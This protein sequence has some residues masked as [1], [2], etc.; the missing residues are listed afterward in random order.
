MSAKLHPEYTRPLGDHLTLR[1]IAIARLDQSDPERSYADLREALVQWDK[2]IVTARLG[3]NTV[4]WGVAESRHLVNIVNQTDYL[5]DLD[6]DEKLGQ[7]MAMVTYDGGSLGLIDLFAMTW[8]RRQKYPSREGRPGVP[9]AVLDELSVYESN[10]NEWNV[11]LAVRWSHSLRE[12]E[13]ALTYFHG[14]GREPELMPSGSTSQPTLL[15]QYPLISQAGLELQWTRGA[16]C[17]QD[18]GR[19]SLPRRVVLSTQPPVCSAARWISGPSSSTA[20]MEGTT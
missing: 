7:L 4:F 16:S 2:G 20:T 11:D 5:D 13:W 1:G 3:I 19:P 12:V 10:H 9:T 17:G 18:R 8:A 15:P 14:T 6:G